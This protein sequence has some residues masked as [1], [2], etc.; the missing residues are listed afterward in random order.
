M[1]V[2]FMNTVTCKL[3]GT[4]EVLKNGEKIIFPY[5]KAEALFYYLMVKKQCFRDT[6]VEMLWGSVEEEIAKKSLR[7][8][9]YVVN[10]T[11][12]D[13]V[14]VSPKRAIIMLNPEYEFITDVEVFLAG[15]DCG[16]IEAYTGEYLEGFLVKDAD[17]FDKWIFSARD[18]YSDAYV[19]KLHKQI[20]KCIKEKKLG[21]V[22]FFCKN[23]IKIDEFNEKAYRILMNVYRKMGLYDKSIDVFNNLLKLLRSELS[24]TP[25]Q[26][27]TELL[28]E[29]LKEKAT[30]QTSSRNEAEEFFYGRQEELELLGENYYRFIS[31]KKGKSI[32]ILGEA[33]LGK[34]ALINRHL[35]AMEDEKL[36]VMKTNC[37][38]AEENYLLKPW[39]DILYQLSKVIEAEN[40]E[41]PVLLQ[42][43]VSHIF[44][45]FAVKD[46]YVEQNPIEQI[47][48]LKYQVA[49]K[50]II[51]IFKHVAK[52]KKIVLVFEDLQ[53]ADTMSFSLIN[54]IIMDNKNQ[55]MSFIISA[56][57]GHGGKIE[58]LLV[59]PKVY[60]LIQSIELKRFNREETMEFASGMM[61]KL[62][63]NSE[64]GNSIYRE[65]EG[66]TFFIVEFLNNLKHNEKFYSISPK[67]Q[68]IIQSRFLSV[69]EEG[70]KILNITSLFFDMVTLEELLEV[71]GKSE[72]EL[73][74]IISGLEEKNLIKEIGEINNVGFAFTHQKLR[75][76]VYSQLSNSKRKI[77]HSRIARLLEENLKGDRRDCILYSRLIHHYKSAGKRLPALNYTI[78]N[79]EYYLCL[80]QEI[81]PVFSEENIP[82][83]TFMEMSEEQRQK[84]LLQ[85]Q[86]MIAEIRNEEGNSRELDRLELAYIHM[87]GRGYVWSGQYRK[88]LAAIRRMTDRALVLGECSFALK[89]YRQMIYFA[90]NTCN[91]KLMEN[92]IEEAIKAAE[93]C[94]LQGEL[95]ILTRLKGMHRVMDG[96]FAEGEEILKH[97]IVMFEQ[98]EEK[99]SYLL[100]I[101]A[102]YNFI[103]ECRR[104]RKEFSSAIPYY[105]KA[106]AICKEKG[107]EQ[108]LPVISTYAGQTAYDMKD[109]KK[110]KVYLAQAIEGY[111]K[112][113]TLWERSTAYGYMAML[114]V[115]ERSFDEAKNC[116]KSAQV[117]ADLVK[118]PYEKALL[119][120]SQ[121]EISRLMEYD[122]EMR[123]ILSD[124]LDKSAEEY[125]DTGLRLMKKAKNCYESD[126]MLNLRNA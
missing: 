102:A 29:I 50:A 31:E 93:R 87:I 72:L 8:A 54:E 101:A 13:N 66:N 112:L 43:V 2:K 94:Q 107:F 57:T 51:D 62:N 65:T 69:S 10:K 105:D 32:V 125:C 5:K 103:G 91:V 119:F 80:S 9:M 88:G 81:F 121:G 7:N 55:T 38:Q 34:T 73:L 97:S 79:L 117:Y 68:D 77:L 98:L 113:N 58:K 6:I 46:D 82:K 17:S 76:F 18:Q 89:G 20:Q 115:K 90:I 14:L 16:S 83:M 63:I 12:G 36:I 84:E 40:I 44:P 19:N 75:E 95:A 118:S 60:G 111:N 24:I 110:A 45:A 4:P 67:M 53:W 47:D 26:R 42:R 25:D 41:I 35:K 92:H 124:I 27:T 100:N 33:G 28:G 106:I 71:S 15:E 1:G 59:D 126:I 49:E 37:Y 30:R 48:I 23:L 99:E 109:Y 3:F 39:S 78:K 122:T 64:M 104:R 74:D 116:L 96:R 22:E 108:G 61:P 85:V 70:M 114:L 86:N 11:F 120:R 56:R 21:E 123:Q 52:K